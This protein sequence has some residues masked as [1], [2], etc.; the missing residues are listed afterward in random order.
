MLPDEAPEE[1]EDWKDVMKV[2][3]DAIMP[4]IT[5][6]Q[7]PHFHAFFPTGHSFASILGSMLS[8]GL[9]VL[10][11][12]WLS[13]PACTELEIVTMNWKMRL[14][15]SDVNGC[16]RGETLK[17]AMNEDKALG[18][19]PCYVIATLGTTATCAFDF[20]SELGPICKEANVWLHV[21]AAYAGSAFIC[22]EYRYLM[23]GIE[24]IDSIVVNANKWIPVNFDCSTMWVRN[25]CDLM[26]AFDVQ[27][28]Y[29]NDI[30]DHQK[31]PDYRHWQIPLGRRFRS[32][33][34]WTVIKIYGAAGI[35]KHIRTQI[36]LALYFAELV[37]AD[38]RFVVEPGPSMG[39]VCFRLKEGENFT[40]QMLDILTKRKKV[41]MV[42][43]SFKNKYVIRFVICSRLTTHED[44]DY[45]WSK[46]KEVAD[47]ILNAD[48]I[49]SSTKIDIH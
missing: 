24:F 6:W 41:F 44:I 42:A 17:N 1:P 31:I 8:D 20:L 22:P 38:D 25:S 48:K 49:N 39:L 26:R 35:R 21:D 5:H 28:A 36:A 33:K 14:L 18:F 37:R 12:N 23:K 10:G 47:L 15:Q 34:L 4:G 32:L 16:L 30:A 29:L 46:I 11:L 3:N 45:S 9:A 40:I 13:S 19:T 43:G 2:I 7:S 27:R